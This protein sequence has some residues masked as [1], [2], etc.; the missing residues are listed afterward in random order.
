MILDKDNSTWAI[1]ASPTYSD[2]LKET[3]VNK[4]YRGYIIDS[5]INESIVPQN[6]ILINNHKNE[7]D[8]RFDMINI[9]T[10]SWFDGDFIFIKYES[11][12]ITYKLYKSGYEEKYGI[13]KWGIS[14]SAN[15]FSF[16]N[17]PFTFNTQ[18]SDYNMS[19]IDYKKH[20]LYK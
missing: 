16:N 4:H 2:M 13:L 14:E 18:I 7:D 11:E 20:I 6:T 8:F 9:M 15:N 3:L 12:P 5:I 17:Y 19:Y 1:V 10:E